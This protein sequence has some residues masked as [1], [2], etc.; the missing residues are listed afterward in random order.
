MN[1]PAIPQALRD[2]RSALRDDELEVAREAAR[3]ALPLI[4]ANPKLVPFTRR[5]FLQWCVDNF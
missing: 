4:V 5:T 1:T 2:W 3:I